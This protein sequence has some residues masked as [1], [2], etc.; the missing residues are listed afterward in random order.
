MH[1]MEY[2]SFVFDIVIGFVCGLLGLLHYFNV[3]KEFVPKTGLIGL[4]CGIVGFV[5]T[6]VYVIYNGIVYTKYYDRALYKT[7][8]DGAFAKLT[9]SGKYECLYYDEPLNFYSY[10][11]KYSDL[12]KKQYNYNKDWESSI[13][14]NCKRNPSAC[15]GLDS[16]PG[17]ILD[18]KGKDCSYLYTDSSYSSFTN[19]DKSQRFL[20]ALILSLFICLTNLGLALFGLMLFRKPEEF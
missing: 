19:K 18:T 12:I 5:L 8:G 3:K 1:N 15:Y 11:A 6:F 20:T 2:T 14:T 4:G 9:S 16:L 13:D 17:P 10:Y 7:D